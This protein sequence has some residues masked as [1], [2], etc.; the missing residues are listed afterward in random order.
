MIVVRLAGVSKAYGAL[1][2]LRIE[3][4]EISDTDRVAILGFD[5]PSAEMFVNLVTG[6]TLADSGEV[7][8]FGRPTAAIADSAEWLS[9]V[10][11]FGILSPRVVLLEGMTAIQNLAVPF[12]LD[13][14]PPPDE[15]RARAEALAREAGLAERDWNVPIAELTPVA[16]GRVKLARSVALDPAVL[17]VEHA[18]AD[19]DRSDVK[20]F[21]RTIRDLAA[22]RGAAG[23]ALTGD[24]EFARAVADR[25]LR[26]DAATGR[27]SAHRRWLG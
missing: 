1:R 16:R 6:A 17:L 8:V 10:D 4:L 18:S 7:A 12:T 24:A 20:A 2:P 27:V 25:V 3:H 19:I 15:M 21:G 9:T 5:R 22:G 11:R 13:I 26:L 14:E 23:I